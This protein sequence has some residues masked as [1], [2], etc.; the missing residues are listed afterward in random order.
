[1]VPLEN[2]IDKLNVGIAAI[3][4]ELGHQ[5]R[6]L[7]HDHTG[8]QCLAPPADFIQA[9]DVALG[10][11]LVL[12]NQEHRQQS[13]IDT[14]LYLVFSSPIPEHLFDK[15]MRFIHNQAVI[16]VA[17]NFVQ[18]ERR[19]EQLLDFNPATRSIASQKRQEG[20]S[21]GAVLRDVCCVQA[22][23]DYA[24]QQVH[25]KNGLPRARAS[26]N[27][28]RALLLIRLTL[29]HRPQAHIKADGLLVQQSK[30]RDAGDHR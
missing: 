18:T 25:R 11:R 23:V 6:F 14:L 8:A 4:P 12:V 2:A 16:I 30:L 9:S 27:D 24:H 3:T 21:G 17:L 7:A 15:P 13:G 20:L 1:M 28:N 26:L 22:F 10:D 5:L 29:D 19:P